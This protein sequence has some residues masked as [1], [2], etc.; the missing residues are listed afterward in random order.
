MNE[1]TQWYRDREAEWETVFV[2]L[3]AEGWTV[4]HTGLAAPLQLE[5]RLPSGEAFYFR[6]RHDEVSL[7]IGGEDPSDSPAW[8]GR[9]TY[10]SGSDASYLPGDDGASQSSVGSSMPIGRGSPERRFE[11]LTAEP[12]FDNQSLA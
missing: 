3:R 7:R 5:G 2:T 11:R 12:F 9:E 8:E 10:G 1:P 4:N 6:S